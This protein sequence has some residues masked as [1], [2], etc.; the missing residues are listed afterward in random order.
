M[1]GLVCQHCAVVQANLAG[2][3]E[4]IPEVPRG[5]SELPRQHG[6]SFHGT[7]SCE[8]ACLAV[9]CMTSL[10]AAPRQT[11]ETQ[12]SLAQDAV[13]WSPGVRITLTCN[14]LKLTR[15][16]KHL[17][18]NKWSWWWCWQ[19]GGDRNESDKCHLKI[20]QWFAFGDLDGFTIWLLWD[21]E[22]KMWFTTVFS[23]YPVYPYKHI[24]IHA[25]KFGLF[26]WIKW[27]VVIKML[28]EQLVITTGN[29]G[30]AAMAGEVSPGVQL[31]FLLRSEH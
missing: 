24:G 15:G 12:G 23:D 29:L 14:H 19:S 2:D 11:P 28:E 6:S 21:D 4:P 17:H 10:H 5:K 20:G 7:F 31:A 26:I 22:E 3:W 25:W 13:Y 30:G 9:A 27:C 1:K 18:R 16:G 8:A